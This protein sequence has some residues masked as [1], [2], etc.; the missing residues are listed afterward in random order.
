MKEKGLLLSFVFLAGMI[1]SACGGGGSSDPA[2]QKTTITAGT[3]SFEISHV[4][5]G[6]TFHTGTNDSG[7]YG[8]NG[9]PIPAFQIAKTETTNKLVCAV[10]QWA[11]VNGKFS[12]T[13][14]DPD[15]INQSTARH[16]RQELLELDAPA[17]QISF[18]SSAS[19]GNE[20]SVDTGKEN[21][22][23]IEITWYG[24]VMF[25]NWLTEM[26][27]S[28]TDNLV[29]TWTDT[30]DTV[31]QNDETTADN[32]KKGFRLPESMEWE[33]A[34]RYISDA[35]G[36][37]DILDEDEY[38]PGNYASGALTYN[39]DTADVNSNGTVDGKEANDSVAVYGAY[40]DGSEWLSTGVTSTAD[41]KNKQ[42]NALGLYNMSGNVWEWCFSKCALNR[43]LRGGSWQ[44][45]AFNLQVSYWIGCIVTGSTHTIG[46]R[47][48]R[49]E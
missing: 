17:C 44:N 15:E 18:D 7:T 36:D 8:N 24:A 22:P 30:G 1:A 9:T 21:H 20:F 47:I 41:V 42:A 31:W 2:D 5:G 38:Y 25:C 13:A 40:Y 23:C 14:G 28:N 45:N 34:A 49:T 12:T 6:L 11:Y 32:T 39:N 48:L 4:P 10:F 16:G 26:V 3:V 43:M 33:L 35:N 37:G 19:A 27:D 29:Y 46:F